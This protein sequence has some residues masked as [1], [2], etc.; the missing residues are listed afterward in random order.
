MDNKLIS[1]EDKMKALSSLVF[2]D[3]K[4]DGRVKARTCAVCSKQRTFPGYVKSG[5]ASPMVTTDGVIIT[6]T[7]EI[8]EGR[9]VAV[10]DIPNA[11]HNANNS[12]ENLMLLKGN[13]AELMVQIDPQMY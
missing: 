10:A 7:I 9:D 11:F 4:R 2:I 3:E 12:E 8:H 13:L 6:S 5:W 1:R